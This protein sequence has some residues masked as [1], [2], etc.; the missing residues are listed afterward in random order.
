MD[1][2]AICIAKEKGDK[3]GAATVGSTAYIKVL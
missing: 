3:D 1:I 2:L